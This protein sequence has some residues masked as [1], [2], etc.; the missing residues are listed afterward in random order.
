MIKFWILAVLTA[1]FAVEAFIL[2]YQ[3][4]EGWGW[5]LFIA[6]LIGNSCSSV[7]LS[8]DKDKDKDKN[9]FYK[10]EE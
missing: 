3:G 5:F 8:K 4:I 7:K 1:I 10:D 6:L 2:A 9:I